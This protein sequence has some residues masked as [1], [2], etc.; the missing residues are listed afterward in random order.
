MVLMLQFFFSSP[1]INSEDI[2]HLCQSVLQDFTNVLSVDPSS[3]GTT[4]MSALQNGL[5]ENGHQDDD[6]TDDS[7]DVISSSLMVK[8]VVMSIATITRL[9]SKG[10]FVSRGA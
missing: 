2:G 5:Q 10:T 7:D 9:Q 6:V 1:D 4:H 3:S 8:L